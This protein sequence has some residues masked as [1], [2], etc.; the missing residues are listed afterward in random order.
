MNVYISVDAEGISGIYKLSQVM[1]HG[2]DYEFTRRMM[3]NDINAAIEGAFLGGAERVVV[4]DSHNSGDNLLIDQL[5]E[6][7]ELISGGIRDLSMAQG[8][9]EGMDCALL[10][11]YHRRKGAKGVIS[12]TFSYSS[13]VE[14][15]LNGRLISEHDLVGYCMGSFDV[16]V[17]FL[18]GDDLTVA[19]ACELV[20]GLYTVITKKCIS[21]NAALCYHP[22]RNAKK[23]SETVAT[24]VR[25]H[26]EIRP[27]VLEGDIQLDVRF[28]AEIQARLAAGLKGTE[29]IDE[30]TVRFLG[31][32]YLEAYKIFMQGITLAGRFGDDA[33]IYI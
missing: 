21:N 20:P 33:S 12:H 3:A 17:V 15:R 32:D 16:P 9:D 24:A 13:M 30:N 25:H 28:S 7:V 1:P 29:R 14:M 10:V 19:D 31:R 11:G 8:V 5:D 27:L 18:S 26:K 4:N 6:R 22:R 2:K 23:I